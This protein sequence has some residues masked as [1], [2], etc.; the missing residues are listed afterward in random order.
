MRHKKL[1]LGAMLL[2]VI[3]LTGLQAQET[4]SATGGIASGSGGSSSYTVGQIVYTTA[5][6]TNGN[7]LAPGVEQPFEISVV[8]ENVEAKG[9]NLTVS[10]FPN[11]TTN[12]L[13]LKVE[14]YEKEK[15]SYQLFDIQGKLLENKKITDYQTS[16]VM[17]NLVTATYFIKV[18]EESEEV[19]T[20][21]IIK[22]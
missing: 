1:K 17:S 6:G 21:K 22:K 9:I 19:K 8:P 15:M 4:F 5:T 10:A 11:P 12:F 2:F 18:L 13:T 7:S 20:F 14:N 16:I 3:G